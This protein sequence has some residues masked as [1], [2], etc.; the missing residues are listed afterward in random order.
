MGA[1]PPPPPLNTP[2][3]PGGSA[4]PTWARW[5]QQLWDYVR[6]LEAGAGAATLETTFSWTPGDLVD[7]EGETS[8]PITVSGAAVGDFA[9]AAP[10]GDLAG[11]LCSA[12]VSSADT[13]YV[14]IQNETGLALTP[15]AGAWAVRVWP[16]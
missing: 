2:I 9:L 15:P 13:V 12:W 14:R 4:T 16:A 11:I 8:S 5:L 1:L 6:S 3:V 7:G 10:P